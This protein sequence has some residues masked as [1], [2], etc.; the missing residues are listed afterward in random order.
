MIYK[1]IFIDGK[2]TSYSVSNEGLIR[3]DKTNFISN[4][5][6]NNCGYRI[7]KINNRTY[8]VHRLVAT[9]FV[10]NDQPDF[11]KE[12]DHIDGNKQNNSATNLRWCTR[13]E[14]L[15]F[16]NGKKI[17]APLGNYNAC[18]RINRN[19]RYIRYIYKVNKTDYK[20]KDLSKFLNCSPSCITEAF[21][22][23]G[24]NNRV[25]IKNILIERREVKLCQE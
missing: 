7:F 17:G 21:R 10:Y 20:L 14:N 13:S 9:Y 22:K 12:I 11:K 25:M 8:L 3:N 2:E 6:V 4:G 1:K 16:K 15:L 19:K 18:N 23:R 24:K 5:F